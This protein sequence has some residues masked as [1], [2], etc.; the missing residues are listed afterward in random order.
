M[1]NDSRFTIQALQEERPGLRAKRDRITFGAS[2][3]P[4]PRLRPSAAKNARTSSLQTHAAARPSRCRRVSIIGT[5]RVIMRDVVVCRTC[6]EQASEDATRTR[7]DH[8]SFDR[9]S[10]CGYEGCQHRRIASEWGFGHSASIHAGRIRERLRTT[11]AGGLIQGASSTIRPAAQ[12]RTPPTRHEE[13]S[14]GDRKADALR[15]GKIA[16]REV[17]EFH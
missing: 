2:A 4:S 16:F 15:Q 7:D 6:S 12:S 5:T 13:H 1:Q 14:G 8:A 3:M 11:V 17:S 9:D 10:P